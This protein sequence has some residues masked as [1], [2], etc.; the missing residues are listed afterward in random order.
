MRVYAFFVGIYQAGQNMGSS[1]LCESCEYI[2]LPLKQQL[3]A[4]RERATASGGKRYWAEA[5]R[6]M[7]I[8]ETPKDGLILRRRGLSS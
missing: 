2:P 8:D 6:A 3:R 4:L 7:G 5:A 1:H